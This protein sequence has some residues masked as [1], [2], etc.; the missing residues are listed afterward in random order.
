MPQPI[1]TPSRQ[2]P[3]LSWGPVTTGWRLYM[4]LLRSSRPPPAPKGHAEQLQRAGSRPRVPSL[5][6]RSCPGLGGVRHSLRGRP[7]LSWRFSGRQHACPS[8]AADCRLQI[9]GKHRRG[10][11]AGAEPG[12]EAQR[13]GDSE[14]SHALPAPLKRQGGPADN[15]R[16]SGAPH[17]LQ[18]AQRPGS[19]P[20]QAR[21]GSA[22]FPCCHRRR[23]G[24]RS[25]RHPSGAACGLRCCESGRVPLL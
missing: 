10:Q 12:G 24:R 21:C 11:Q 3:Q 18:I 14:G 23:G 6:S 9:T 13:L 8:N 5:P 4:E 22:C 2:Q 16:G 25:P 17:L 19:L 1:L 15:G 7:L 20:L